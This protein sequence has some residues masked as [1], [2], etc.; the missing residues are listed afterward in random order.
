MGNIKWTKSHVCVCVWLCVELRI[1]ETQI[2]ICLSIFHFSFIFHLLLS[3]FFVLFLFRWFHVRS[4]EVTG[5]WVAHEYLAML[6]HRRIFHLLS[7]CFY[8]RLLFAHFPSACIWQTRQSTSSARNRSVSRNQRWASDSPNQI[9]ASK[10][11]YS[12]FSPVLS[13]I[14][15]MCSLSRRIWRGLPLLPDPRY[16]ISLYFSRNRITC[17][18]FH[19]RSRARVLASYEGTRWV[20]TVHNVSLNM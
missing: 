5:K 2:S 3:S 4:R 1:C 16:V 7:V 18:P 10:F 12:F 20:R 11:I 19:C 9:F 13:F 8:R 17:A 14:R 6:S 15:S